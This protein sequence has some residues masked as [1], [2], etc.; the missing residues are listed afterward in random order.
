MKNGRNKS[1]PHECLHVDSHVVCERDCSKVMDLM[2]MHKIGAVPVMAEYT[3]PVDALS[4]TPN[5]PIGIITKSDI[6]CAYHMTV[7][8]DDRC[9]AIL[10]IDEPL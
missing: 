8:S 6:L 9:E 7:G 3:V 4:L 2:V 5:M 10:K 1:C